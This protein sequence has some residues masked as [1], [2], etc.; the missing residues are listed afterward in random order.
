MSDSVYASPSIAL[1]SYFVGFSF[2]TVVVRSTRTHIYRIVKWKHWGCSV[3]CHDHD[4]Y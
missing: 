1:A 3:A 4:Q 2:A